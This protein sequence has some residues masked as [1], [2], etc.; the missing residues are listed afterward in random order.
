VNKMQSTRVSRESAATRTAK[1][2]C[3]AS[4]VNSKPGIIGRPGV[5]APVEP[6]APGSIG[7]ARR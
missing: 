5:R 3:R 6:D 2:R 7:Y 1:R 4:R